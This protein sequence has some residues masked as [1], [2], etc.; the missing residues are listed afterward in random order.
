[1][2]ASGLLPGMINSQLFLS[3]YEKAVRRLSS[4]QGASP[5]T[6]SNHDLGLPVS[7][8]WRNKQ[9]LFKPPSLWQFVRAAQTKTLSK[10]KKEEGASA[11][12]QK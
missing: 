8:T 11:M 10:K 1:M 4:N 3:T 2:R 5:Q 9:V 12:Y 6:E 7:K